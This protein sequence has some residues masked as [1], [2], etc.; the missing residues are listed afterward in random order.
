MTITGAAV[1]FFVLWFLCLFIALQVRM[2]TQGDTGEVEPGTPASAP[3]N[4]RLGRRFLWVTLAT[5]ALWLPLVLFIEYGS[6][7][8]RDLDIFG[9]F[10][11]GH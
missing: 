3:V 4:L 6:L 10:D 2:T 9:T 11:G 7:T 1:L 5:C 8:V